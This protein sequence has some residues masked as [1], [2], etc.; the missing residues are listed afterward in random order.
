MRHILG[1]DF[2]KSW[3]KVVLMPLASGAVESTQLPATSYRVAD[4]PRDDSQRLAK[5]LMLASP[6]DP[7]RQ[8]DHVALT[9]PLPLVDQAYDSRPGW[10][11]FAHRNPLEVEK[12]LSEELR[13]VSGA[14]V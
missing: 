7:A 10:G 1:V 14:A 8:P 12:T 3:V 9:V 11:A 5:W 2:G 6:G 4:V 13:K